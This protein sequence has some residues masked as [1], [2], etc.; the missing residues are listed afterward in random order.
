MMLILCAATALPQ[1]RPESE[2]ANGNA[3]RPAAAPGVAPSQFELTKAK[4][5]GNDPQAQLLLGWMYYNGNGLAQDRGEAFKWW[6]KAAKQGVGAAQYNVAMMY[7]AGQGV[8]QDYAEAASWYRKTAAPMDIRSMYDL[9]WL[10]AAGKGVPKSHKQAMAWWSEAEY[11]GYEVAKRELKLSATNF[12]F[13]NGTFSER[14]QFGTNTAIGEMAYKGYKAARRELGF[15]CVSFT[16]VQGEMLENVHVVDVTPVSI[17]HRMNDGSCCG[18]TRLA[19]LPEDLQKVFGYDAQKAAAYEAA[20][21]E[22]VLAQQR[23]E[24]KRLREQA[25]H[26]AQGT[27]FFITADGY[28]LT[29]FH[30]VKDATRVNVLT[31]EDF[32][33]AERV[34]WNEDDD[35]ALLKV[36]GTFPT[37]PLVDSKDA[38]KASRVFTI[39]YPLTRL[40]GSESKFTDGSISSLT[41][42]HGMTNH[43]QVTVPIQPGNSGGPLVDTKGNVIGIIVSQASPRFV[44]AVTGG[45]LPQNVNWAVKSECALKL[46]KSSQP[47]ALTRLQKANTAGGREQVDLAREVESAV[48]LIGVPK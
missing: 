19:K 8:P 44:A 33:I 5:D 30:V 7:A 43:F 46:L 31:R 12:T 21:R 18:E 47:D 20:Q 17:F 25:I 14:T 16:S 11:R 34:A 37:V 29:A 40:E 1:Q 22:A 28:L 42:L 23:A 48:A 15:P 36:S 45:A 10:F 6:L 13:R 3:A 9:G 39:G 4:A 38:E 35:V 26:K 2:R 32:L 41:G 24:A 27:G